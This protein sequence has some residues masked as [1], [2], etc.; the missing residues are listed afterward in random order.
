MNKYE[1]V[2]KP[3][4]N[5]Y[6][7][8]AKHVEPTSTKIYKKPTPSRTAEEIIAANQNSKPISIKPITDVEGLHEAYNR[9]THL[10]IHGDT[11]Y[12]AGTDPT[13]LQDDYDDLGIPFNKT[14]KSLR[15]RN[16]IDLLD[17]NP[18][19]KNIVGHS[20]GGSVALE[21]QKNFK[22]RDYNVST[23]G[24]PVASASPIPS[25]R[26]RNKYD[27]VSQYDYGAQTEFPLTLNPHGY[28]NFDQNKVSDKTFS[29]FVY[30]TDS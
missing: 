15:Y 23:Y 12:I 25:N 21:L 28:D 3:K 5:N 4:F 13:Y 27:P 26:Y 6:M 29:S 14:S 16:T 8:S 24:A 7:T 30:R 17:V 2:T 19:V 9:Q 11:L 20:L 10:Y 22:Y 18:D 1:Y